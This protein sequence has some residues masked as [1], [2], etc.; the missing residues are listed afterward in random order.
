[1]AVQAAIHENKLA[2]IFLNHSEIIAVYLFGSQVKGKT[3][4]FSDYDLAVCYFY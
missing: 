4:R 1:M 3:D 2:E